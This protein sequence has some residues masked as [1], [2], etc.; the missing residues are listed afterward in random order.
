MMRLPL[1]PHSNT[2]HLLERSSSMVHRNSIYGI[3]PNMPQMAEVPITAIRPNPYQPRKMLPQESIDQLAQNIRE[4]GLLSPPIVMKTDESE[5]YVLAAGQ[6]RLRAVEK[7]GWESIPVI[8]A[9][10]GNA[11]E[12]ALIENLQRED[13]HPLDM[14]ESIAQLAKEF[15]YSH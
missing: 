2:T 8:I 9:E 4:K 15:K 12:I 5:V 7:L 3:S 10:T 6:R 1:R 14:A 13:P 11:L